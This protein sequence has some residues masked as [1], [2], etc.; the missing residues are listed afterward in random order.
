MSKL[1]YRVSHCD[2]RDEVAVAGQQHHCLAVHLELSHPVVDRVRDC[3]PAVCVTKH[4][5]ARWW[6]G[7]GRG[8]GRGW[9]GKVRRYDGEGRER[10]G[11]RK[12][13]G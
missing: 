5:A 9:R 8:R 10:E 13:E 3:N 6:R 12:G 11:E 4:R 1:P 7:R 2:Q